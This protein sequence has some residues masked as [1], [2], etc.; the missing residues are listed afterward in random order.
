MLE[1]HVASELASDKTLNK[2]EKKA[3]G[4]EALKVRAVTPYQ[5]SSAH[6]DAT[7]SATG[8]SMENSVEKSSSLLNIHVHHIHLS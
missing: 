5:C 6:N 4:M 7:V 2:M 8:S 1:K 3:A